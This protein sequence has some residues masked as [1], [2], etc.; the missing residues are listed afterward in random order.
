MLLRV[1]NK[2]NQT[3]IRIPGAK[4]RLSQQRCRGERSRTMTKLRCSDRATLSFG[5]TR[6]IARHEATSRNDNQNIGFESMFM[7][8]SFLHHAILIS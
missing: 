5:S 4:S 7:C 6:V 2:Y 1:T 3:N 8:I